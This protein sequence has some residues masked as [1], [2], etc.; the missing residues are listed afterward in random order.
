MNRTFE[1]LTNKELRT[2]CRENGVSYNV[3]ENGKKRTLT[4]EEMVNALYDKLDGDAKVAEAIDEA[5]EAVQNL[6]GEFDASESVSEEESSKIEIDDDT[7]IDTLIACRDE[8]DRLIKAK[9]VELNK[10]EK[11]YQNRRYQ[12]DCPDYDP[13]FSMYGGVNPYTFTH[14]KNK[15]KYIEEAQP[16]T[17]FAFLDDNGKPRTAALT[18]R[19]SKTKKVK[20]ITEFGMEFVVSYDNVMWVKRQERWARNIY[21]ILKGYDPNGKCILNE[22][23]YKQS[24]AQES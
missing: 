10:S 13:N 15:E 5:V 3:T 14:T 24:E 4:K 11:E 17:L 6:S 12:K 16:G 20:L 22:E 18:N 8:I 7:P 19:S 21:R 23:T 9:Y 2:V 1:D